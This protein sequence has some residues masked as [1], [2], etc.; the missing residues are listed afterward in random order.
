MAV[1]PNMARPAAAV[2]AFQF[3]GWEYQPP[4][5]D[6]TCLGY[7]W[8]VRVVNKET[9]GKLSYGILPPPPIVNYRYGIGE[10]DVAGAS[11]DV[12]C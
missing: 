5:G 9:P 3:F 8:R 4:A 11:S 10:V 2:L 6:H 1:M 7:L 12:E